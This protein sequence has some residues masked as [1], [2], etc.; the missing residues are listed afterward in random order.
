MVLQADGGTRTASITGAYV[1]LVMAVHKLMQN[2]LI[3][4]NPI[5]A[6][7]AAISVGVVDG[8]PCWICAIRRTAAP[9]PT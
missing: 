3:A 5:I 8:R 9:R 6:Q 4:E 2:G 7:V 1:A